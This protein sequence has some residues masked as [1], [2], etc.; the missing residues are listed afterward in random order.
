[1]N[2]S[3]QDRIWKLC[4]GLLPVAC[5]ALLLPG[6]YTGLA[7]VAGSD[8]SDGGEGG[9][10]SSGD[11]GEQGE[12]SES[13]DPARPAEEPHF[14]PTP[15]ARLTNDEFVNSAATLLGLPKDSEL[16]VGAVSNLAS[17]PDVGGLSND[18]NNQLL[19]HVGISAYSTVARAMT[20]AFL[21]DVTTVDALA[22][23]IGCVEDAA[24]AYDLPGCTRD[25]GA[26]LVGKAFRREVM[27]QELSNIESLVDQVDE[28]LLEHEQ[29]PE[30][31][32][33]HILRLRTIVRY[34]L[35]SAD[36][37]LLVERGAPG[38]GDDP[39]A[40]IRLS[41]AEIA[42]RLAYFLTGTLPDQALL[43]DVE[44]DRLAD[45]SVRLEHAQRLLSSEAGRLMFTQTLSSWLG[46]SGGQVDAD[47]AAA[48]ALSAFIDDWFTEQRPFA[49]LYQAPISVEHVDGTQTEEP[50][51]VLGMRAF[52]A[53]H[54]SYPTPGF[55][56]RGV[57]VVE[58]LLCS[59]LPSDIPADALDGEEMT[60]VEVF[61]EHAKQPCA[62][63]HVIFD[64]YGA[65]FQRFGTETSLYDL[66]AT[67][68]GSSFELPAL[69]DVSGPVEGVADLG[70]AMGNSEQAPACMAELWYRKAVRR[71]L[72]ADKGDDEALGQLINTWQGSGDTSM[73]SLLQAIVASEDFIMLFP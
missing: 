62:T 28:L 41:S 17:E 29:D 61:E 72:D 49:A 39:K 19:T 5:S 24:G 54:S 34:V 73:K 11:G 27:E 58:R 16:V 52:V 69:G 45:P 20:D 35:L 32:D 60:P 42:T 51:G 68:L 13:G 63:C 10:G 53:S 37:L 23:R 8:G 6:C 21:D 59:H 64:N 3:A 70:L 38:E 36:F 57:F 14:V 40:P 30:A 31:L 2:H 50:F 44:E 22:T 9:V 18:A 46:V 48:A 56:T 4:R 33:S 1:M 55:I 43:A 12:G 26:T 47:A 15:L 25:F 7:D 65:A 67:E 66:S 71:S